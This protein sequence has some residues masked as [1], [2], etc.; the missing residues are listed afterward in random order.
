MGF[1][2]IKPSKYGNK[3][4]Q[5]D[6]YTFDSKK[7]AQRY[8]ELKLLFKRGII[9][10]LT[11][12]PEY[13]LQDSFKLNGKTHRAIKYISDFRYIQDGVT[14]VEDTKGYLTEVYKIKRKLFLYKYG[15]TLDFREL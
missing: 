10:Q 2:K 12:Q 14:I 15:E 4:V 13:L 8:G 11:L 3:K 7:E 9:E 1:R 6:G 5:V